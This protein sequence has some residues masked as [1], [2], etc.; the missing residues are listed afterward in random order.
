MIR[1][2]IK[3]KCWSKF[4]RLIK[5]G[6]KKVDLRVADFKLKEGDILLLEEWDPKK[7]KYSGKKIKKKVKYVLKFK[8][9]DFDQEKIIKRCGF[10]V[11][12]LG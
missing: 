11:I 8:L 7:K 10:Y 6:K 1:M 3:K 5:T 12:E 9:N 4:F 2:M